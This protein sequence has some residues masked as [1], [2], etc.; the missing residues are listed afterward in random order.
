MSAEPPSIPDGYPLAARLLHWV[1]ALCV[2]S[3]IPA[4]LLMNQ[5]P[6]GEPQNALYTAHRSLGVL[7]MVLSVIR[8]GYRLTAKWPEQESSLTPWQRRAS[9]VVHNL[10]YGLLIV[11]P[12]VGWYATS[13]YG[14]RISVFGLFD[15]PALTAKNA[16]AADLWFNVHD[17]LG[18]TLAGLVVIHVAAALY[19]H[20]IRR[21]DVLI[22]MLVGQ[23]SS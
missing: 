6:S 13:A 14:A 20:L 10:F 9:T 19:H 7:V 11:Q 2:L 8:L 3:L 23:K 15:L 22:R 18:F 21:D 5:L 12:L 17:V 1:I 16:A 4:G